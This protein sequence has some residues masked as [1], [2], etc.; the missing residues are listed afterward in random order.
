MDE[1]LK[2]F[3]R[4]ANRRFALS[5]TSAVSERFPYNKPPPLNDGTLSG[6]VPGELISFAHYDYLGLA[7]DPR[8]LDAAKCAIDDLGIGAGASRLVG[9]ELALHGQLEQGL[10][11]FLGV[12]GALALVSGYGT[13][14]S[15]VAH[16]LAKGD[17]IL[18]DEASHNSIMTGAGLSRAAVESFRHND[19]GHLQ[20]ILAQRRGLHI[21]VLVIVEGLYSMD[22]DIPDLPELLEICRRHD[23]WLMIDEAHSI[24][25][26]G[27]TGRGITEHFA[28]PP[29]EV[30][31]IVGTL[32]KA[33]GSCGGFIAARSEVIRWLRATLPGFVYSVGLAPPNAAATLAMLNILETEPQHLERLRANSRY[34]L[35]RVKD[36][37]L[38]TGNAVGMAVVPIFFETIEQ[39]LSTANALLAE[40]FY[41]PPI[42]QIAVPRDAPRIRCF[43]TASHTRDDMGRFVDALRRLCATPQREPDA[44]LTRLTWQR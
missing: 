1:P 33:F 15:L 8:V 31:L 23:A 37:G 40:G 16:L 19:L 41:A 44:S 32:S 39:T 24:G 5:G 34:F 21:R 12:D 4:H 18:V 17:L 14:V 6:C 3:S 26:L 30:D 27:R 10:A 20:A 7:R 13:N 9:G 2:S 36:A 25:V 42:V 28:I 29:S 11:D 43:I 22:G 35:D 38:D